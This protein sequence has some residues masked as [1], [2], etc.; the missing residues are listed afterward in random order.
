MTRQNLPVWVRGYGIINHRAISCPWAG[1]VR[2][3]RGFLDGSGSRS[4]RA[5]E[6]Q[7]A[8]RAYRKKLLIIIAAALLVLIGGGAGLYFFM[9]AK[10]RAGGCRSPC[11]GARELH[12]QSADDD[13]EP[14][15]GGGEGDQFMKLSV[16]IEVANEATMKEIQPR[17][18]KVV[19]AFQV[20]LRELRKIRS[21]GVGGHLP[22]QGRAAAAGRTSRSSRRRIDS[23]P[24]QRNPG[25]VMAG[26]EDP[27]D[28]L[29]P[30]WKPEL[31]EPRSLPEGSAEWAAML[32]ADKA[33]EPEEGGDRVLN[34]DEID[35]LL[36][37]DPSA[38]G[39][40]EGRGA[41]GRAG[42]DQFGAGVL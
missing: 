27:D 38:A 21:R 15:A 5:A 23:H 35:S 26:P 12:L 14:R 9:F 1:I 24:V 40:S 22:A 18:A 31:D 17:M 33:E 13:G 25:A 36:G 32:D 4:R 37:F 19:D 30:D 7:P 42:A 39:Q 41:F 8:K 11:S 2:E 10:S 28:K 3:I 16:A 20:Y 34:Q 6:A 29:A